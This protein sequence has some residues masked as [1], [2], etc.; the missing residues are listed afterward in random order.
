M[1][2]LRARGRADAPRHRGLPTVA[3]SATPCCATWPPLERLPPPPRLPLVV[4]PTATPTLLEMEIAASGPVASNGMEERSA[5]PRLQPT[6]ATGGSP[7][8]PG[9]LF[10]RGLPRPLR[11]GFQRGRSPAR[12]IIRSR[13][14]W[15]AL[16]CSA[17]VGTP[18]FEGSVPR[19]FL[20]CAARR[21]SA[22]PA[23]VMGTS[24]GGDCGGSRLRRRLPLLG[25]QR[26]AP[27]TSLAPPTPTGF[28][29]WPFALRRLPC[30]R[31]WGAA[32]PS[33]LASAA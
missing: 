26:R 15:R 17:T 9:R 11:L 13:P 22:S 12:C 18:Q 31:P 19:R 7:T 1:Q 33:R 4:M 23:P 32:T 5:L 16:A 28:A 10:D 14:T 20:G 8:T 3:P 29:A 25:R 27:P 6:P 21:W 30:A 2:R 24:H